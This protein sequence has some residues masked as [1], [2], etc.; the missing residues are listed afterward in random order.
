[1]G[2]DD[3]DDSILPKISCGA[4]DNDDGDDED[5]ADDADIDGE[6]EEDDDD[7]ENEDDDD[8][9]EDDK[10]DEKGGTGL[11]IE[12]DLR[13]HRALG[14]FLGILGSGTAVNSD[15]DPSCLQAVSHGSVDSDG[16]PSGSC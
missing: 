4:D 7:D 1:M 16:D 2:A 12:R 6:E 15:G 5:D 13:P 14:I 10:T 8:A 11:S 3:N 9:D